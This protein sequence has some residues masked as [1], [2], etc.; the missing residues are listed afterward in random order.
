MRTAMVWVI[1]DIVFIGYFKVN[2]LNYE[3]DKTED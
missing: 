1:D 3:E 2:E